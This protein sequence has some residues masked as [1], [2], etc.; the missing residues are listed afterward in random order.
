[1]STA[2]AL[3]PPEERLA[4]YNAFLREKV[5][6]DRSFGF[7]LDPSEISP[8][9]KPHQQ[10]IVR[11][12]VAGGRRAIFARFGLG[13]SVM[14]LEILR[15]ILKH[16]G[17]RQ[18]IVAPLGVRGEFIRDG[19]NLL[20]VDVTFVRKTDELGGDG[21]YITNYESVRDGKLDVTLFTAVSLDEASVLRSYGSKTYQE[22]LTL[23]DSIPY[24][25]VATA[26]PSP[27]RY[28]ELI[29]Y[30]G[31][32]G[33]MDT[34][35][36]LTRFFQ[37]NSQQANDLTIYP[38]KTREFWL[39]LNTWATFLQRPSDL[40]FDDD[41]YALPELNVHW[42]TVDVDLAADTMDRDGQG[43]L[44]RGGAMSLQDTS[45][46]KRHSLDARLAK[47]LA[48]VEDHRE[49]HPGDQII[50]WCDLN[51]E[52]AAIEKALTEIG[53]TYSSV[54]GSLSDDEV[55]NRLD[56]WRRGG[57][58][59]LIGKPV[60]LG[61]GLNLQQANTAVWIGVTYKFNDT[62]QSLH[63][64]HRFGQTRAVEAHF[65]AAE[66][67][68]EVVE[69]LQ[70]K[71]REHDEL[72]ERM[73]DIIREFG[74][75][76]TAISA[77]LTRTMGVERQEASGADWTL[78]LN[79]C[80]VEMI[81]QMGEASV[82][83]V[84]TSIPFSD[85]Y[86]YVESYNDFGHVDGDEHF[87]EQMSFWWPEVYRV[88]KPGRIL[89]VHVKD[90]V[91]FGSVTGAGIPTLGGFE[92]Q[93]WAQGVKHGFDYM[94]MITITTDVVREN[95]QTYR[96]SYSEMLKDGTKMGVGTPEY[97]LLFHK[98]QTDRSKGY[99]DEPVT[100]TRE[101]FS[102]VKWQI[103][104][105]ADWRSSGD[106]LLTAEDLA[107]LSIGEWS[108][109]FKSRSRLSLYDY[110]HHVALGTAMEERKNLPR[111]FKSL[112]P[113]SWSPFVWDDVNRMLTLNGEQSRR[114]L[115][116]HVCLARDSRVLTRER[117]YVPI[118]EVRVGE[119]TLTHKGRW[120]PVIAV[121]NTGDREVVRVD[122]QGSQLVVTPDH[123]LW[124]RKVPA[125]AWSVAHSRRAAKKVEPGWAEASDTLG[126]YLNRKLA[127]AEPN[128]VNAHTWWV[129]GRWLGDGHIDARGCAVISLGRHEAES[130][131]PALG[132]YGGNPPRDTG[133]SLQVQLRDKGHKLRDILE[134][135]GKGAG[136]KHLPPEAFTLPPELAKALLDGYLSADG[137]YNAER[138]RYTASSVSRDLLLGM[139]HLAQS[140]Y[141]AIASVYPGRGARTGVIS[142]RTVNMRADWV[143]GFDVPDSSR[144]KGAPFILDD[145]AW[146]KVRKITEV[147][148]IE[149][150]NLR[151]EDDESFTAEGVVVKNCPLQFDIVDR[152]IE[153]FSNEGDLV[154]DPFSGL[155]TVALRARKLARRGRG[156]ELNPVSHRDGVMYQEELDRAH[157]TPSLF[158]LFDIESDAA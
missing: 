135:C 156:V 134:R 59:A 54:H 106:R 63:R 9:L 92:H 53:A 144:M 4:A 105:A 147:G 79:D 37:R 52:Q 76:S 151:V 108:A 82:D 136:G 70:A 152:L 155:S 127:P 123:K 130:L 91:K 7:H 153:R 146:A 43:H 57:S 51:D 128:D 33:I 149:T 99:A 131:I 138:N 126:S 118:Q 42:H 74:L 58:Y 66:T 87:W 21:I 61:Q 75:S 96:L 77:E 50:L 20:G 107:G 67:E 109:L 24:R 64:V 5:H 110:A 78:A 49:N 17:G 129:V 28:K 124:T 122:S 88:L 38:H 98:P 94:G 102:L 114:D 30:A 55:E 11:W 116:F 120:R 34:G 148:V 137:H 60:M 90:R 27:N 115:E 83:L 86:E 69:T 3:R 85:Q 103:D 73:S 104:A 81:T 132:V 45:R 25:F 47:L 32:L 23:F 14:Q 56:E 62:I 72:T 29:H 111:T 48:I 154:F 68:S 26:T 101:S 145:G 39:W 117:G 19:R 121:Q 65:I 133:T 1:M 2:L 35:Q 12:A 15:L 112:D 150:W 36:A 6:F 140:A 16:K 80:V 143:L 158:D 157:E 89:A 13:K 8:A 31:F 142:G 97:V 40:G 119:H 125:D 141:G 84:V 139:A 100:H 41:G 93:T 95:N 22:F 18:L 113:G 44:F 10:L 71:W 46:E